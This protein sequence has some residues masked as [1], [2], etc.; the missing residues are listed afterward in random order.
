VLL[1]ELAAVELLDSGHEQARRRFV[2]GGWPVF[3]GHLAVASAYIH[4]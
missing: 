2:T 1:E 3:V 4:D